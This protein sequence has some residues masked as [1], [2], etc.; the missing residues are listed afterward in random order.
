MRMNS[1]ISMFLILCASVMLS[2]CSSDGRTP[3]EPSPIQPQ[4]QKPTIIDST[5]SRLVSTQEQLAAGTLRF[6]SSGPNP[7]IPQGAVVVGAQQGGFLRRAVSSI[8]SG[9]TLILQTGEAA[10]EQT[11]EKGGFASQVDL[12]LGG[13]AQSRTGIEFGM[14]RNLYLAPGAQITAAGVTLSGTS[15]LN[16][17][18]CGEDRGVN[19][20]GCIHVTLG[21]PDGSI[22]LSN[23]V[24]FGSQFDGWRL[25]EAH[26]IAE[27]QL[28]YSIRAQVTAEGSL[29]K[30]GRQ[31]L[32]VRSWPFA[33]TIGVVPVV[34]E[35]RLEL[36]AVWQLDIGRA[37][38]TGGFAGNPSGR[39]GARWE[40]GQARWIREGWG[41]PFQP[42]PFTAGMD[43]RMAMRVTVEPRLTLYLYG[44]RGPYA[45]LDPYL[46]VSAQRLEAP[47]RVEWELASG[48]DAT[49]GIEFGAFSQNI[50]NVYATVEGPRIS[51]LRGT[52]SLEAERPPTTTCTSTS[53]A[54][55]VTESHP[56]N[57]QVPAGQSF[58]KTW[59][60]RN[61]GSNCIWD[62]RIKLAYVSSQGGQ[63]S[64]S[65]AAVT[66]SGTV[67]PNGT[68]VFSVPMRAPGTAGTYR[69]DWRLVDESG[70][71]IRVGNSNTVWA[72]IRVP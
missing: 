69:E 55:V 67:Q 34:G 20:Q 17:D 58:T 37:S 4:Q 18:L 70:N 12:T 19:E 2:G 8:N 15:L 25:R 26:F 68:Y 56:D 11:I 72:L 35:L 44:I 29:R 61:N 54:S 39:Y 60:L 57:T 7:S 1:I 14:P 28:Q 32:L 21:L 38:L 23:R 24:D 42:L 41:D 30:A 71:T 6:V 49:T 47:A 31:R 9:D 33:T 43:R 65:Q 10:L 46:D 45:G 62:S 64:T 13:E 36:D 16:A 22:R 48:I 27:G 3:A 52:I 50:A 63:L 5:Q 40:N 66:V 59:T 53:G 51:L